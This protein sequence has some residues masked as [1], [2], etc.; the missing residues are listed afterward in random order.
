MISTNRKQQSIMRHNSFEL[1]ASQLVTTALEI[2]LPALMEQGDFT[3][4]R[5]FIAETLANHQHEP[6]LTIQTNPDYIEAL[7]AYFEKRL[8]EDAPKLKF[9]AQK[10]AEDNTRHETKI[11]WEHGGAVRNPKELQEN[12]SKV[13][14]VALAENELTPQ[15]EEDNQRETTDE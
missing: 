14:Q 3:A 11:T 15:N 7:Q 10:E 9:T 5:I 8:G 1:E 13:L 4:T 6:S 2:A 12:I